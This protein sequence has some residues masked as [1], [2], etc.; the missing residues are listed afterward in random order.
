VA[1]TEES[2]EEQGL[3][4][5]ESASTE[6]GRP[7]RVVIGKLALDAHNRGFNYVTMRLRDAGME[8]IPMRI[9]FAEELATVADQEDADVIGL[10]ILTGGHLV[11]AE[12]L[13]DAVRERGLDDVTLLVGG[14]VPDD[15]IERLEELGID[16]VF[17]ADTTDT[18]A[19]VWFIEQSVRRKRGSA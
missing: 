14:N 4:R 7:I 1:E 19:I 2:M 15:D 16:A 10:S 11:I 13:R 17:S 6:L 18:G 9:S 5:P 12:D 8:V 3:D